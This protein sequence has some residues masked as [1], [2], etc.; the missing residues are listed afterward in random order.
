MMHPAAGMDRGDFTEPVG[1][2]VLIK[3]LLPRPAWRQLI[4]R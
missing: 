4:R 2:R 3:K 1:L